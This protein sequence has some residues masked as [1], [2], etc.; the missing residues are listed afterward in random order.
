[1]YRLFLHQ[2]RMLKDIPVRETKRCTIQIRF[3]QW[4]FLR[5]GKYLRSLLIHSEK[6]DFP[7][8]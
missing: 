7:R 5:S 8:K 3:H 1:M 4:T 2:I 6:N